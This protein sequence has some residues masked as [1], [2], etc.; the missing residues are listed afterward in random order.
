M[1][2][3]VEIGTNTSKTPFRIVRVV[4]YTITF[5]TTLS[6]EKSHTLANHRLSL[7]TSLQRQSTD[8]SEERDHVCHLAWLLPLMLMLC[9]RKGDVLLVYDAIAG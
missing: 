3:Y 1:M 9:S 2:P 8:G 4:E 7:R 5:T 6:M